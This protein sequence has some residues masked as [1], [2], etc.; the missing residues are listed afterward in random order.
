MLIQEIKELFDKLDSDKNK[1]LTYDE[2]FLVL[3]QMDSHYSL[4]VDQA[5]DVIEQISNNQ[6]GKITKE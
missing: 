5:R 2:L 1:F 6:N 4:T 3:K